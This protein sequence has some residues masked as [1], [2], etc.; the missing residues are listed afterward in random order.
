MENKLPC[1]IVQ[2]LLPTY[3][4][5]L[6]NEVTNK[7]VEK[8]IKECDSCASMLKRM[9]EPE[10]IEQPEVAEIDYL[11]KTRK[12]FGRIALFSTLAA[13]LAV[14]L[15]FLIRFYYI[16]SEVSATVL[17]YDVSVHDNTIALDGSMLDSGRGYSRIS[18]EEK[19]GVVEV[20]I[21]AAPKTFL[22]DGEFT[23]Q[24][25]AEEE[26]TEVRIGD[27][28]I[29]DN[30]VKISKSTASLYAAKNPYVGN[31]G[32]NMRVAIALGI[33]EKIGGFTNELHTDA[34]PYGWKL[35]FRDNISSGREASLQEEMTLNSY[36]ILAVIDNLSY[37]T[38][39]YKTEAGLQELTV[40]KD[41]A[42][43]FVGRDI[44][45]FDES[46]AELQKLMEQLKLN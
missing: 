16:G 21:Y 13:V 2:D 30:G 25:T 1:E 40:D 34:E 41:A 19:D 8:H 22:N 3:V 15:G 26:I 46:P 4:D 35:I 23:S 24:Y 12:R 27:T 10:K 32:G 37:V 9:R 5:G 18:F 43:S 6:T 31:M 20:N 7:A 29:W 17:N 14:V 38:W 42:S 28:V 36:A 44:K 39:E 11:K 45:S 33:S